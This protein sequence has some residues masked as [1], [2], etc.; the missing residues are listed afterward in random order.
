MHSARLWGGACPAVTSLAT[1]LYPIQPPN[2]LA[3]IVVRVR[4][5]S[6]P[7]T[8]YVKVSSRVE[9]PTTFAWLSRSPSPRRSRSTPQ[10]GRAADRH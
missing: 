7:R 9:P 3:V 1:S 8:L 2:D 6:L 4:S 10:T 5:V